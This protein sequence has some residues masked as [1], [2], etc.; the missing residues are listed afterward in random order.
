MSRAQCLQRAQVEAAE[1]ESFYGVNCLHR[2]FP[3]PQGRVEDVGSNVLPFV[4]ERRSTGLLR[5][6]DG[7]L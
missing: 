7:K 1:V 3:P 4:A 5:F 6:G 2:P